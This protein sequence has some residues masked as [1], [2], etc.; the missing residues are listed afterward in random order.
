VCCLLL[1]FGHKKHI[2]VDNQDAAE[3]MEKFYSTLIGLIPSPEKPEQALKINYLKHFELLF[4][5]T[6]I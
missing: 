2:Y 4:K 5:G 6:F 1:P 3:K